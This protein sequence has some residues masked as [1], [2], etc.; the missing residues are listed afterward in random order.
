MLGVTNHQVEHLDRK[1]ILSTTNQSANKWMIIEGRM[2]YSIV[3]E[4]QQ[5]AMMICDIVNLM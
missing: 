2:V 1:K 5:T 4:D 3:F